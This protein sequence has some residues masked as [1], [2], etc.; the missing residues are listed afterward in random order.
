M[1]DTVLFLSAYNSTQYKATNWFLRKLR[2]VVPHKKKQMQSLLE[3]HHLSFVATDEIIA[4]VDGKMEVKAQYDYVHQATTFSFKP[5]DSAEKENDASDSLK[6]SGFYINLRH[7]QSVLVDE[8]YFKIKFT[9]WIEPFLVWINGQMYQIDAGAFMMNS[10]LFVVFEVINYKTGEPLT[11]DE[12][13]GK[14]G[15]YNLL[16]V[17]KYQ[18]FNEEKPVEAG[19]KISEII[20]ENIS[21]FFWELTNKSYRSQESSFVHDTLVFSNNIESIADYF[22][23]LI[24]TKAP[25]EPI[26][27]ISTVEIYKYYPQAGCSVI[28]DFDYNNFNTVLY[29]AIILEALK[30]Y[31]H[32]F[33][34]SNLEH[35]TDLRRSVRNDIYLQNL[36]CSPNLPIETHNL[37]NYIKESE[38]YKKHAEALHLKISYLTAQNELKKSRNSTILNVLL[39]IISLLSAIGT[40]D[41]IEEHFG[42]PFKYSF[43]IVVALFI[44]GLFW[45]IIEYRNHRKL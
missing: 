29:P 12:V 4:S 6:D 25:V 23:K 22:C 34:N 10:V 8:R 17:E 18:F 9:F 40:L 21:E 19:I 37:L 44:L 30:L 24:S 2:N 33:Q 38:P 3:K 43:I 28:C 42:V 1:D 36:F 5:K 45:G 35:E 32:V 13:E 7:A 39:Y 16:S 11:K 41:V 15:N 20:Y 27:D 14:A 31:I 26:K